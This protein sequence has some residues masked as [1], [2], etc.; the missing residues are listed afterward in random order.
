MVALIESRFGLPEELLSIEVLSQY[1]CDE[2]NV[3]RTVRRKNETLLNFIL[4][5]AEKA[6]ESDHLGCLRIALERTGQQHIV[7][8]LDW[9]G[10]KFF[11]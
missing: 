8:Y 3:E 4:Q 10:G 9:D 2:I 5:R 11:N 1:A 7:N 6:V